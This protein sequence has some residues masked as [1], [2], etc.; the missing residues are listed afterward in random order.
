MTVPCNHY[1]FYLAGAGD[2][3]AKIYIRL[4]GRHNKSTSYIQGDTRRDILFDYF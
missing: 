2:V 3:R 4:L 1:G